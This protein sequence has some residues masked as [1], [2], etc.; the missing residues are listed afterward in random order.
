[1][2]NSVKESIDKREFLLKGSENI[3]KQHK[4]EI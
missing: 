1:M 4:H 2:I 3:Y